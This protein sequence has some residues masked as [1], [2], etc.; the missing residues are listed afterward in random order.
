M[1]GGK[2]SS[3]SLHSDAGPG[4]RKK[5]EGDVMGEVDARLSTFG[6]LGTNSALE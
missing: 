1:G 2:F 3:W 4:E 5:R 6:P